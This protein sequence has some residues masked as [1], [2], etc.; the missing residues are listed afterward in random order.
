[1]ATA[2]TIRLSAAEVV[3]P[4]EVGPGLLYQIVPFIQ[5]RLPQAKRLLIVTDTQVAPL[6]LSIIT[7]PLQEA[8]YVVSAI[9]VAPGEAVKTLATIQTLYDHAL[10][11]ALKRTDGVIALGGGIIGDMTGFFAVTYLRGVPFVQVP[12]TL[13]AQVDAA[14][15]GKV[16]V[17]W[18]GLK[19]LVGAFY[20]P[21]GVLIDT[22]TLSTL[23]PREFACGMAEVI[24]YGFIEKSAPQLPGPYDLLT[25]LQVVQNT[26]QLDLEAVISRCCRIKGAVVQADPQERSGIR[27]ILNLGHTFGHAYET[28]SHGEI[29]HGEA[30]AMG[31]VN[32]MQLSVSLGDMPASA[33]DTL[34]AVLHTYGLPFV[35][36]QAYAAKDLLAVMAHD[37]KSTQATGFRLVLP[38]SEIGCVR[39]RDDIT[40]AQLQAIL[41][42]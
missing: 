14:V 25:R 35:P 39:V 30:V 34:K 8:G 37:K 20:H 7:Q 31:M 1:M 29:P 18:H 3:Y 16:A 36:P 4:I 33:L 38:Y 11:F 6:Y 5:A 15:G 32:A 9:Q 26:K 42:N 2:T 40:Q 22:D 24:K 10:S 12:T 13:L 21:Q 17:N 28:L 19:N 23:P 41:N 27:E